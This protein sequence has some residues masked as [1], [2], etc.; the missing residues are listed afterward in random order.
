MPCI[1]PSPTALHQGMTASGYTLSWMES[2]FTWNAQ[3][4]LLLKFHLSHYMDY[5]R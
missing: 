4:I 3:M 5:R 2:Y 1:K